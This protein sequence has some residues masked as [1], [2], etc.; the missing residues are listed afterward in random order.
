MRRH[1]S[2]AKG[3]DMRSVSWEQAPWTVAKACEEASDC[4]C[5]RNEAGDGWKTQSRIRERGRSY[6]SSKSIMP[7]LLISSCWNWSLRDPSTAQPRVGTPRAQENMPV[8]ANGLCGACVSPCTHLSAT[9]S[10]SDH[11]GYSAFHLS[12]LVSADRSRWPCKLRRF[13]SLIG[14]GTGNPLLTC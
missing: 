10:T 6:S 5:T 13:P 1:C 14:Q 11:W 2:T 3:V 12:Q 7:S 4:T 9:K 8:D